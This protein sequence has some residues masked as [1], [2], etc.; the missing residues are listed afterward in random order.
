M[1]KQPIHKGRDSSWLSC[2][3]TSLGQGVKINLA[4]VEISCSN[5]E[6]A[7]EMLA[8]V[9]HKVPKRMQIPSNSIPSLMLP[10]NTGSP[11]RAKGCG[12][13]KGGVTTHLFL[14]IVI[15]DAL[16]DPFSACGGRAVHKRSHIRLEERFNVNALVSGSV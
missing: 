5:D 2:S 9:G 8:L 1:V 3:D 16:S 4:C 14:L 10:T 13:G 12:G 7:C 15:T 6:E 11:G